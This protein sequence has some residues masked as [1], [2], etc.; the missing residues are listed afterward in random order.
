MSRSLAVGAMRLTK[1]A[2][3]DRAAMSRLVDAR[4]EEFSRSALLPGWP[5]GSA[6]VL[7]DVCSGGVGPKSHLLAHCLEQYRDGGLIQASLAGHRWSRA[8]SPTGHSAAH[9]ASWS[10]SSVHAGTS[11]SSLCRPRGSGA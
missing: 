8:C 4:P 5:P 11:A 2:A 3:T 9:A 10:G 1:H 7:D 6:R